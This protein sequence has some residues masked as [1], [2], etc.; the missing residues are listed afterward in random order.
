VLR[1]PIDEAL[2]AE[3]I[4][5]YDFISP[6]V[7]D[8]ATVID[9]EA[10][11]SSEIHIGADAMGGSGMAY[12]RAIKERYGLNMEVFN[13]TLDSTFAFMHC[14]K[15]GKIRM[16]CSSAYAMAGLVARKD[17]YD[18]SF[19]NDTDFDRHGI[20][21]KSVGLM[22][23]NHYLSVAINY[24]AQNRPQWKQSLGIGKTLVSSSMIDR[25]AEAL[26]KK[27]VEV[28]VGFKWFVE[29]LIK[30]NIFFGGEESAGASFLRKDGT[31]W[32]TDKD[33][34]I[35][36]LLAAEILATTGRDPGEHYQDLTA[37]FGAPLYARIDA[38]ANAQQ[39]ARLKK[40]TPED[41]TATMLGGE[42][43]EAILTNAPGNGAAIGG[44]KVVAKNGWFALRPSGTEPIYKIYAESFISQTHLEQI[45]NEAQTI[46][47]TLF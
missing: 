8:L 35:M 24:L 41:I 38:P 47:S 1:I 31:V 42:P 40:L 23:P 39:C 43:I 5:Q 34:I 16:D 17:D 45:Q 7:D 26:G 9:M 44:L 3:N 28:P 2:R 27:V 10:I 4:V 33:G 15:D 36:T 19:G 22:N 20:V 21:T 6:Y 13:D 30:G 18:I 14:D 32:S 46:V 37:S 12:Y 25:V 11:A 29:G